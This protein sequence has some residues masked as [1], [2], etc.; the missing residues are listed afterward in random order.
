M[1]IEVSGLFQRARKKRQEQTADAVLNEIGGEP[2]KGSGFE[3]EDA[4]TIA[5]DAGSTAG[6]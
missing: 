6:P 2:L 5:A 1:R 4:E 3:D